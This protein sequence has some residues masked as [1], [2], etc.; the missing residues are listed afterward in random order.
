M[1]S[2]HERIFQVCRNSLSAFIFKVKVLVLDDISL[3]YFDI[4]I[5]TF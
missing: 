4:D 2:L 3:L 1:S 5:F